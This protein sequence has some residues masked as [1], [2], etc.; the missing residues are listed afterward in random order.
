MAAIELEGTYNVADAGILVAMT[1]ALF[2][3]AQLWF[4]R[5]DIA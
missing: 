1:V 3:A 4:T 2:V 5:V